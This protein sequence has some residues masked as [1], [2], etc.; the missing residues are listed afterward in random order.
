MKL[1]RVHFYLIVIGFGL[2]L[3]PA[4]SAFSGEASHGLDP[5]VLLSLAVVL[6]AAVLAGELFEKLGQPA[7]LGELVA[8]IAL[9]N[10]VYLNLPYFEVLKTNE[11][12]MALA[13]IGVIILL[14]E[15]G[16]ETNLREMLQV[17]P[18]SF[19]VAVIGVVGPFVLGWGVSLF[20]HPE[21]PS[22]THMF[23]GAMI[24][25][26]SIGITARVLR[27]LGHIDRTEAKIILGAAV[28]DDVLALLLLGVVQNSVVSSSSGKPL[29]VWTIVVSAATSIGFLVSAVLIGRYVMPAVF[30]TVRGFESRS[31]VVG[32]SIAACFLTAYFAS[33]V[34]LA[35]IIGAFAA[36]L[37]LEEAHFEH[38]IDHK[39][40]H[41]DDF[42][43]PLAALWSPIF[44]VSVGMN[45][46]LA[47][48]GDSS[49]LLFAFALTAAGILSKLACGLGAGKGMN[50]IA[51]G[52]GMM[53]RGEVVLYF[54]SLGSTLMLTVADGKTAPIIGK[55]TF[56][57]IVILSM[58]TA[59]LTP[60]LLKAAIKH[61]PTNISIPPDR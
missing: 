22:L 27:D 48:F 37:I 10:L 8:G 32:I 35:A 47:A 25:A 52:L 5:N 42:V 2:F 21:S 43:S 29:D 59:V 39:K 49:L 53:P 28:I 44:F 31:F 3:A 55:D 7:V 41:L 18:R 11:I 9:G 14:F 17:G 60:P 36:G 19:L 20:F 30:K 54:A 45:V 51:V 40:H 12:L 13:Q 61:G 4:V 57:A 50:K 23:I 58:V 33:L 46:D 38:F 1:R 15:V 16:L 26:T 24:T 6:G 34:G 56:N